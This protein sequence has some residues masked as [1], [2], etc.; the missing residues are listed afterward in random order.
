MSGSLQTAAECKIREA[1]LHMEAP[2]HSIIKVCFSPETERQAQ[3]I[4]GRY[5]IDVIRR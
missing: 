1:I 3:A 4:V 5:L 2:H